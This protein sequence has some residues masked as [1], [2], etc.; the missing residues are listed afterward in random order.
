MYVPSPNRL[1]C[2]RGSLIPASFECVEVV[3]FRYAARC[4]PLAIRYGLQSLMIREIAQALFGGV[5]AADIAPWLAD[6]IGGN[7]ARVDVLIAAAQDFEGYP[8]SVMADEGFEGILIFVDA[9]CGGPSEPV[10]AFLPF[11]NRIVYVGSDREVANGFAEFVETPPAALRIFGEGRAGPDFVDRSP[12]IGRRLKLL[13]YVAD[14]P[15]APEAEALFDLVAAELGPREVVE[16]LGACAGSR[17]DLRRSLD[18]GRNGCNQTIFESFRFALLV[19]A[20][21]PGHRQRCPKRVGDDAGGL[22]VIDALLAGTVPIYSGGARAFDVLNPAAVIP[23]AF[24]TH[25][26]HISLG[27]AFV[28]LHESVLSNMSLEAEIASAPALQPL[29][30]SRLFARSG[31]AASVLAAVGRIGHS[32]PQTRCVMEEMSAADGVWRLTRS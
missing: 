19:D 29:A 32:M 8:V 14:E 16:A 2:S 22:S 17:P 27:Q 7:L 9:T 3:G 24:E 12:H 20:V 10:A 25:P 4:G 1:A 26:G 23:A 13:A 28:Y 31:F 30:A 21:A 5:P 11:A 18:C 15:C 6:R